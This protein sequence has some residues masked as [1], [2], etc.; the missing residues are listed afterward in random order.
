MN[1]V[2]AVAGAASGLVAG[3]A[4]RG[5]VYRLS[6]P[7]G[8]PDR[9]AC[10]RCLAPLRRWPGI[11]CRRCGG[12]LGKPAVLEITTALVLALVLGRFADQP[13]A[14]AFAFLGAVGVPL[15]VIDAAV[16]RLPDRLTL[17]AIPVLALLLT[18]AAVTSGQ[19]GPLIRSLLCGLVLAAMF[20]L[21]ALIRPGQLGG[22][23]IKLAAL[24][25]L[26]LGW[27]GWPVLLAG[28]AIGFILGAAGGLAL[29]AMRRATL[30][31]QISFG[32]F[33]LGGA[34]IAMLASGTPGR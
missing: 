4:L 1:L 29:L 32:P 24:L 5:P 17:T 25:G 2:W 19:T 11:C 14:A 3:A 26:A 34:L 18:G 30:H 9:S 23:D 33:L 8:S 22:G 13:N 27:L 6:V 28:I 15:A 12:S 21:L 7:T 20:L 31:S 10:Q 16:R